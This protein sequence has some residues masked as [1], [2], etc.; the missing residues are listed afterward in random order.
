M[1]VGTQFLGDRTTSGLFG[2]QS[3]KTKEKLP[4][5]TA[6]GSTPS[7]ESN[8]PFYFESISVS[9]GHESCTASSGQEVPEML[10][11]WRST[12]AFSTKDCNPLWPL[13]AS[14]CRP[15]WPVHRRPTCKHVKLHIIWNAATIYSDYTSN[16]QIA[17]ISF[18][19]DS[20]YHSTTVA[21]SSYLHFD[22]GHLQGI[23]YLDY[24]HTS[25][26]LG[27]LERITKYIS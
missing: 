3:N 1:P 22:L 4:H 5:K 24:M 13:P 20:T 18:F 15:S 14:H 10:Q 27:V 19:R 21:F 23:V 8:T 17:L 7:L 9:F 2:M 12:M 26:S 16:P 25:S 11:H 6:V